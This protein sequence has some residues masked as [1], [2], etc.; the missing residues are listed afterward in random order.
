MVSRMAPRAG[1]PQGFTVNDS[2]SSL[3]RPLRGFQAPD[4]EKPE[5]ANLGCQARAA[6]YWRQPPLV[7][8]VCV[9]RS[10]ESVQSRENLVPS[11]WLEMP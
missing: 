9:I 3:A 4:F 2:R 8:C 1:D 10:N 11:T 5:D 6:R 7:Y